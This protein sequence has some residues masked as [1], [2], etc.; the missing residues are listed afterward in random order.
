VPSAPAAAGTWMLA[1]RLA[2]L[3]GSP[4]AGAPIKLQVRH[5]AAHGQAVR[6]LTLA[7]AHTDPAG[8]WSL[9][10][11]PPGRA[12]ARVW[13][14]AL[15][16]GGGQGGAGAAVSEPLRTPGWVIPALPAP[17]PTQAASAPPAP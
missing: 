12:G 17:G 15:Y 14:R 6:E 4:I 8:N 10:V 16:A 13:L 7:E 3:D 2:L 5:V 9:P 11:G 1:G